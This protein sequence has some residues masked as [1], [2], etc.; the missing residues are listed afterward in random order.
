[1]ADD[2]S[3]TS[4]HLAVVINRSS[5]EVYRYAADPA[6]IHEWAAGLADADLTQ[7]DGKWVT[8]S[9]MGEISIDF[10]PENDLGVLDHTVTL[11][12]GVAVLNPMRVIPVTD[13]CSEVV[14]S[15]RRQPG[16]SDE[17]YE[18]DGKAV[19]TDLATLKQILE[20]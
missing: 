1:M 12:S 13:G 9:P 6:R 15:L 17:A 3:D 2:T 5:R 11:P 4:R 7:V 18:A 10:T 14:F 16:M 19:A 20:G 8:Q